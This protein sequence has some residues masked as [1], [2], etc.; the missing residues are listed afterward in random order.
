M[1]HLEQCILTPH[2]IQCVILPPDSL[3]AFLSFLPVPSI[4]KK[5]KTF[6]VIPWNMGNVLSWSC[7]SHWLEDF[8][9][10]C[11]SEPWRSR[12]CS[13][14]GQSLTFQYKTQCHM[15]HFCL[16]Y[17]YDTCHIV[18]HKNMT[19]DS[20]LPVWING[21]GEERLR[22]AI[23]VW[24]SWETLK[25]IFWAVGLVIRVWPRWDL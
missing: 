20:A 8:L 5:K 14:K 7:R 24:L 23:L 10:Y 16:H 17:N 22:A 15:I 12:C 1:V 2:M 3:P 25:R 13:D 19:H 6:I 18:W 21:L 9:F 4:K 11:S